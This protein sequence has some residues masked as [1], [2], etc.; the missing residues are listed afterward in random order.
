[1]RVRDL[2]LLIYNNDSR[3]TRRSLNR[4]LSIL[5]AEGYVYKI[6]YIEPDREVGAPAWV[7]GLTDKGV[8]KE[9]FDFPN[10]K[11]FTEH[12]AR[13]L[14]HELEISYFRMALQPIPRTL[15]WQQSDLKRSIHPDAYFTL[16]NPK[17]P[18]GKNTLHYFL[19]VEKGKK[20]FDDLL[21]KLGRYHA[22]YNTDKAKEEWGMKTFR[23]IV[24]Q[25]NDIRR[26][27]LLI[28]LRKHYNHRMFYLA[29]EENR[30]TF[31]TPKD[32]ETNSYTL[33]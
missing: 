33:E 28:E 20:T 17:L 23:V 29:T 22:L 12:S 21:K 32:F 9:S 13:T 6:K 24:V 25:K 10:A 4:T 26:K 27:N 3:I 7:W 31:L 15:Y 30:L 16:T 1:M 2:A 19:E 11:A 18:E 8:E 5:E 14:D